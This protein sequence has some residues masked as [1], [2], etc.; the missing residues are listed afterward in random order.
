VRERVQE[1]EHEKGA[2]SGRVAPQRIACSNSLA[3]AAVA[4]ADALFL[5]SKARSLG[6]RT[7]PHKA[8]AQARRYTHPTSDCFWSSVADAG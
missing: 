5:A 2:Q 8:A 1:K 3:S 4:R 7:P 6:R